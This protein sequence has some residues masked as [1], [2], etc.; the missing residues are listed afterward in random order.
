M[1]TYFL[2]IRY[3]KK[4]TCID[5]SRGAC[6]RQQKE[7]RQ[8]HA[9]GHHGTNIWYKYTHTHTHTH[10]NTRT[11]HVCR[12]QSTSWWRHTS[13]GHIGVTGYV[14]DLSTTLTFH[15]LLLIFD[16]RSTGGRQWFFGRLSGDGSRPGGLVLEDAFWRD[17]W[18]II[19]RVN[20][21]GC[22]FFCLILFIFGVFFFVIMGRLT[23]GFWRSVSRNIN[24]T[25]HSPEIRPVLIKIIQK[26]QRSCSVGIQRVTQIADPAKVKHKNIGAKN[27][28]KIF[29]KARKSPKSFQAEI[30]DPLNLYWN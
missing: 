25:S 18:R 22:I 27:N 2:P 24:L 17:Y 12:S 5:D 29:R 4:L 6:C 26:V 15:F 16:F 3:T 19:A 7:T 28:K 11:L 9:H 20:C 14:L 21:F 10:T 30:K 23:P 1:P 13:S 8:T